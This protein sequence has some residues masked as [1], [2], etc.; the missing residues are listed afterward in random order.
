MTG[1]NGVTRMKQKMHWNIRCVE[2]MTNYSV[3]ANK[4]RCS[5]VC[6]RNTCP[7]VAV[8]KALLCVNKSFTRFQQR[9]GGNI[10]FSGLPSTWSC[11]EDSSSP[12]SVCL[13]RPT[14]W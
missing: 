10:G 3:M 9:G 12:N 6:F 8:G 13:C 5:T 2:D 11:Q 7:L 1:N 4:E 14:I